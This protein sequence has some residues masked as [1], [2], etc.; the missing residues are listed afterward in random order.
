MKSPGRLTAMPSQIVL[1][2]RAPTGRWAAI[3]AGYGA[4]ASA[5]TPT[6]R[7]P[8]ERAAIAIAMPDDSPPPPSG[9][10][11]SFTSGAWRAISRP[12]VPWPATISGASKAWTIV[13]PSSAA[14]RRASSPAS[15]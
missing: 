11:T 13:L 15:S 5:W 14:T 2:E 7:A 9:T 3:D 12:T 10:T 1:A 8:G 6:M 4:H